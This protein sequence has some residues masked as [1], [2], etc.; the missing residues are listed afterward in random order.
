MRR[1]L[2]DRDQRSAGYGD[3]IFGQIRQH[4]TKDHHSRLRRCFDRFQAPPTN[5]SEHHF[6]RVY[7]AVPKLEDERRT[8]LNS[9]RTNGRPARRASFRQH[10]RPAARHAR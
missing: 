3:R 4:R 1:E 6:A 2:H 7:A 5:A 10:Q 9:P 8:K